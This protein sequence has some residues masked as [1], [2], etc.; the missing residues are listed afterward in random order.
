[1]CVGSCN[2]DYNLN[3]ILIKTEEETYKYLNVNQQNELGEVNYK[4]DNVQHGK[5]ENVWITSKNSISRTK[6]FVDFQNDVTAKDIKLALKE[7]FQSIEHVKRYTTTG[8]ATDQGKTSNVNALGII[9]ELTNTEISE[10]GT[11][12]FRLPYKPVTFGAIA[13]RHVKEFFDL[14]RTS[15]MHQWHIDN[16]ALFEDVGQWKRAWYYPQKNESF[17][18]ALNREVKA[19]RDS[20]GILDAS[21]LGKIDIKGRDVSEFL[22]RIYTN[23]WSKLE[24]GKCRYGVMLGDDGMVIDDGVTTRLG[25]YHYLMSTTT[26]NAASVMS[27][28]EDWL[29]TEWPELEVYLTSVTENYGTCLLYTSPSPRD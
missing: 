10:L 6:M 18:S 5:H 26:G 16:K 21:T 8:M 3:E 15:P 23:S 28:L 4:S 11:T 17:Q 29:Q 24:I 9:S 19:T 13:G 7:G 25:E 14:E 1:M 22:N 12:T 20:L 2:G 27:K